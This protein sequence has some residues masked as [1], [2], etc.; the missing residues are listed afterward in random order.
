MHLLSCRIHSDFIIPYDIEKNFP[1]SKGGL[2]QEQVNEHFRNSYNT[3]KAGTEGKKLPPTFVFDTNGQKIKL[4]DLIDQATLIYGT[5]SHCGWGLVVLE[6]DLPAAL[7][8][9][10]R[11]SVDL[12]TIALLVREKTEREESIRCAEIVSENKDKYEHFYIIDRKQ[13]EK[14]N[15]MSATKML[16]DS[17][18]RVVYWNVGASIDPNRIYE[19][20]RGLTETPSQLSEMESP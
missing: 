14:L 4:N 2:T 7:E 8:K 1:D 17:N 6:S 11:D 5:D 18:Q 16:I 20:L 10:Q 19:E 15:I 13:A 12:F 3:M 9:L